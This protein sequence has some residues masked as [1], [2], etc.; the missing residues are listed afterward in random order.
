MTLLVLLPSFSLLPAPCPPNFTYMLIL[1]SK[2]SSKCKVVFG[3]L[4]DSSDTATC[5][6]PFGIGND[7]AYSR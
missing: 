5:V 6:K 3:S 2:H 1:K 4:S 7:L